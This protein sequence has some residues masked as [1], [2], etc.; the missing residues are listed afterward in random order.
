MKISNNHA[1]VLQNFL[2]SPNVRENFNTFFNLTYFLTRT[3]LK[4]LERIGYNLSSDK[5]KNEN[6]IDDLVYDI[7]GSL[8][9]SS[10]NRPYFII[11]EYFEKQNILY[12]KDIDPEILFTKYKSLLYGF[13]HQELSKILK[14]ENLQTA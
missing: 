8:L 9:R 4:K 6:Y 3:Y 2:C 10:L 1:L 11:F 12:Y 7:L 14:L 13:I 5:I